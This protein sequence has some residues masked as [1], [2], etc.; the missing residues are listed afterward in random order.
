MLV[1]TTTTTRPKFNLISIRRQARATQQRQKVSTA[2][3]QTSRRTK[4]GTPEAAATA[5]KRTPA[6]SP[7]ECQ[8]RSKTA[9][10]TAPHSANSA[11]RAK[12]RFTGAENGNSPAAARECT[13]EPSTSAKALRTQF[14]KTSIQ[15]RKLCPNDLC[16]ER[17]SPQIFRPTSVQLR[18]E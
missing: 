2:A 6:N 11:T 15:K 3:G 10:G 8:R 17:G 16:H 1:P 9:N 7:E 5:G 13:A 14:T 12:A 4:S 18:A